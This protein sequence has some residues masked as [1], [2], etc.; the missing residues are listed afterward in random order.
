MKLIFKYEE[1]NFGYGSGSDSRFVG[2]EGTI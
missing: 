1:K 2:I